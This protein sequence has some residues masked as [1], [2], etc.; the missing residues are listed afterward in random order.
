MLAGWELGQVHLPFCGLPPGWDPTGDSPEMS[1]QFPGLLGV[2]SPG[3]L[4]CPPRDKE[5]PPVCCLAGMSPVI[6]GFPRHEG[7]ACPPGSGPVAPPPGRR[8][9]RRTWPRSSGAVGLGVGATWCWRGIVPCLRV[10]AL[11]LRPPLGKD[12]SPANGQGFR[13]SSQGSC[14]CH[15]RLV[16]RTGLR[17]ERRP[18]W[19]SAFPGHVQGQRL[20]LGRLL[21]GVLWPWG[22]PCGSWGPLC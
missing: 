22:L 16:A 20:A 10:G 5:R 14:G 12:D 13:R 17:A 6:K 4:I 11:T 15:F 3:P 18:A 1:A 7:P 19:G 2:W 9:Q 8:G 21:V